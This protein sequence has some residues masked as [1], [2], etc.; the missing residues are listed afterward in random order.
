MKN[1]MSRQ[2]DMLLQQAETAESQLKWWVRKE[3]D[4][5]LW[6]KYVSEDLARRTQKC[7]KPVNNRYVGDIV[8]YK[9][10]ADLQHLGSG[11]RSITRN[12]FIEDPKV[13]NPKFLKQVEYVNNPYKIYA[14]LKSG[15]VVYP[16]AYATMARANQIVKYLRKEHSLVVVVKC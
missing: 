15:L 5:K 14:S 16:E 13:F 2:F 12:E 8:D 4:Y 9:I 11:I 3:G 10:P 6:T 1:F 7:T